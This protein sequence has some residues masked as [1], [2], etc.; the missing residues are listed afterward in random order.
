MKLLGPLSPAIATTV[1][2]GSLYWASLA[3]GQSNLQPGQTLWEYDDWFRT[4]PIYNVEVEN[5]GSSHSQHQKFMLQWVPR[6]FPS[7]DI[8]LLDNAV[9]DYIAYAAA[10]FGN[11]G[12]YPSSWSSIGPNESPLNAAGEELSWS[13]GTGQI[14]A[15]AFHPDYATNGVVYCGSSY[16]GLFKSTD[17][18]G[19]WQAKIEERL[20]TPVSDIVVVNSD[21]DVVFISTGGSDNRLNYTTGAWRSTDGGEEWENISGG[22]DLNDDGR[23]HILSMEV[24]QSDPNIAFVATKAG[25]FRTTNALA[26]T[27]SL[28]QWSQVFNP[29]GDSYWKGLTFLHGSSTVLFASAKQVYRSVDLGETWTMITGPGTGLDPMTPPLGSPAVERINLAVSTVSGNEN[30]VYALVQ[31]GNNSAA[32]A[33]SFA[34]T[35]NNSL[36]TWSGGA[37]VKNGGGLEVA[38]EWVPIAVSPDPAHSGYI[39]YGSIDLHKSLDGGL[40]VSDLNQKL[41][42]NPAEDLHDD[43][44]VLAFSPNGQELWVGNHGGL[45]RTLNPYDALPVWQSRNSGLGV[46]LVIGVS[47]DPSNAAAIISG[48]FDNGVRRWAP[49]VAGENKWRHLARG[50]GSSVLMSPDGAHAYGTRLFSPNMMKW[51]NYSLLQNPSAVYFG[52]VWGANNQRT[53]AIAVDDGRMY[54]SGDNVWKELDVNA[55]LSS[56]EA[57]WM[58]LTHWDD[59][60]FPLSDFP[61]NDA[62]FH[63]DVVIPASDPQQLY[64]VTPAAVCAGIPVPSKFIRRKL[65]IEINS[66]GQPALEYGILPFSDLS[67]TQLE[68]DPADADRVWITVSG[69]AEGQKVFFSADRGDSWENWDPL[70]SLPN[71]PVNDIV[72]QW[73][74]NDGLYIAMDVGVYYR[75]GSDADV[76]W[77]PFYA[78]LPNVQVNDLEINYCAGKLRAGTYGRGL[79]ESDLAEPPTIAREITQSTTWSIH[80][81]LAQDVRVMPG[82][83]LTITST[84]NFA[85]NTALIIEPGASVIVDGGLLHNSC[86]KEWKGVQVL[87]NSN[88]AQNPTNQ[89]YFELRNGGVIDNAA[90]GILV[91]D[92]NDLT[93]GGGVV[94]I[95]GT[96]AQPGG[97]VRDCR[98]AIQFRPYG[99]ISNMQFETR[100]RSQFVH[101]VFEFTEGAL[102]AELGTE[103]L[104]KLDGV[105]GIAFQ[106]CT[107]RNTIANVPETH[108]LGHGLHT[109]GSR[110]VVTDACPTPGTPCT[111]A[112]RVPSSFT[113]LDHGVHALGAPTNS[114]FT[115]A[116]CS[117]SNTICGVYA[118][119]ITGFTV[120]NNDFEMT[121]RSITFT[122][123]EDIR[124]GSKPRSIFSTESFGFKIHDNT[125]HSP[126][127]GTVVAA[128]A[129]VVGYSRDHNDK[130]WKNIARD[131][132]YGF[133]GEGIAASTEPGGYSGTIGLQILCNNCG[134]VD[135]NLYSRKI[136]DQQDAEQHTIRTIQASP[137]RG[138]DNTLDGWDQ[139]ELEKWD[140]Y[141]D[142]DAGIDYYYRTGTGLFPDH[143]SPGVSVTGIPWGMSSECTPHLISVDPGTVGVAGMMLNA[144]TEY[145]ET[146]YLYEE[147]IDGGNTDAVVLEIV[148]AWPQDVW[149]LRTYLLS[150]SPYL[151]V[152]ALKE[153]IDKASVPEAI[154]AE[155]CI[156]NPDATKK[157]G[158]IQWVEDDALYPLPPHLI[159]SIV[160][161]WDT[162][163]YRSTLEAQMGER[164][165]RM[166]EAANELIDLYATKDSTG[167]HNDS[168]RWV[169]QQLPTVAA[170]YAEALLRMQ[171]GEYATAQTLMD[172]LDEDHRLSSAEET[173]RMRMGTLI[174]EL[175]S[176]EQQSRDVREMS[177]G[178]IAAWQALIQDQ[179][180]RPATWIS[181]LLCFHYGIC[182]SPLT[183]GESEP[184]SVQRD[185]KDATSTDRRSFKLQPNPA[186]TFVALNYTLK[187]SETSGSVRVID[188]NGRTLATDKLSGNVGQVVLDTR[189]W[190]KGVYAVQCSVGGTIVHAE[191]LVIQ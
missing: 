16:G 91:G 14:H 61:C 1:I 53:F 29:V 94:K 48:E 5:E 88:L 45:H 72:Y 71:L 184:K 107:F 132:S 87:G 167:T 92:L 73:G 161:S 174:A 189:T 159:A 180:D 55:A 188:A 67:I 33:R 79:W 109:Y 63:R 178:E 2:L 36:S 140:F 54:T 20:F 104:I 166:T 115:V 62:R 103:E 69:Y 175:L 6:L 58:R 102:Q 145:G 100:N 80:K 147:L 23:E 49:W 185:G 170:R 139:T 130:I 153:L 190:A 10:R 154:K 186:S 66:L 110:F 65:P 116:H 143:V 97:T 59:V 164:H 187:A 82:A 37:P 137:G 118:S 93:K 30:L 141:K 22:L 85:P 121:E 76:P 127:A 111:A 177:A 162:R 117:F 155:I 18:G 114:M 136:E 28:V 50:D 11:D 12:I 96:Q 31:A 83:T 144:R 13:S 124:F 113:G 44:Q 35:F 9:D 34:Y 19:S 165:G 120:R 95:K 169:W 126:T 90:I 64:I 149:E 52:G 101:A 125:A 148:S 27:A 17:S 158:F 38:A 173:E 160:A 112:E 133:I 163:T 32:G 60:D 42:V 26:S 84:A 168:L 99:Q 134:N 179:Y 21:P 135:R 123:V 176:L 142:S 156:A 43:K 46:G 51:L 40:T 181:N 8:G 172:D 152:E 122:G 68:V 39:A 183:G 171:A 182:R 128:E 4:Q 25:I 57:G 191:R 146:R 150:K 56:N 75:N 74:T 24:L 151:S 131:L 98:P 47:S 129:I 81:N 41:A 70:G 3:N 106:A 157:E 108:L 86:G 7:G 105:R 89:G 15:I 138:A 78:A 77:Q 119:G